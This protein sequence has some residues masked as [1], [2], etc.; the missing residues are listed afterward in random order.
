MTTAYVLWPGLHGGRIELRDP[1]SQVNLNDHYYLHREGSMSYI[2]Q[3]D[4]RHDP[5]IFTG[6][7]NS[8]FHLYNLNEPELDLL[9]IYPGQISLKAVYKWSLETRPGHDWLRVWIRNLLGEQKD[10]INHK[11][12]SIII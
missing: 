9:I 12:G 2:Q 1:Y 11:Y 6:S 4:L 7:N 8:Q 10:L 5:W 3:D